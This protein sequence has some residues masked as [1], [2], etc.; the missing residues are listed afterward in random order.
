MLQVMPE[1]TV[2]IP[3]GL[4]LF[5]L[6]FVLDVVGFVDF[7]II[8]HPKDVLARSVDAPT[9][10]EVGEAKLKVLRRQGVLTSL[11]GNRSPFLKTQTSHI[12]NGSLPLS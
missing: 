11:Q 12:I 2:E 10:Q 9:E 8:K 6:L 1:F 5:L 7:A 3:S 4:V